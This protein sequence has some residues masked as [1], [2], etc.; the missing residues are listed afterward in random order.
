[1]FRIAAIDIGT[2]SILL[3]VAEVQE[4]EIRALCERSRITRL[5]EA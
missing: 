4:N 5:G 2:N 1:M 3:T